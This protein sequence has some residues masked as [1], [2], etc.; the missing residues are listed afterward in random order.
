VRNTQRRRNAIELE[1]EWDLSRKDELSRLLDSLEPDGRA[2]IDLADVTYV[3]STFLNLL[4]SLRLRLAGAEITLLHPSEHLLR[5]LKLMK[6]D[7]L[8]Q[9]VG[10]D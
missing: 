1:G 2:T 7:R 4:A 5:V 10:R 3:D 6:F 8:F 9:I